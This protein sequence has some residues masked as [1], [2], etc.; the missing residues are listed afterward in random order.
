MMTLRSVFLGLAAASAATAIQSLQVVWSSGHFT[1][2]APPGGAGMVGHNSG[3]VIT[4]DQG[5]ELWSAEYPGDH[6]PCY[7]TDGGRTFTLSSTCWSKPRQFHC[8]ADGGGNP[9]N[10]EI[11]DSGGNSIGYAEGH[12]ETHFIGIALGQ[13]SSCGVPLLLDS[14]ETCDEQAEWT[15]S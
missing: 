10:C 9:D 8:L 7:S 11:L 1:T 15:V 6:A 14:D 2:I 13:D 12:T 5:V 3:F 4:D